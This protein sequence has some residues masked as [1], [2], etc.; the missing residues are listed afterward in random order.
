MRLTRHIIAG[1]PDITIALEPDFILVRGQHDIYAQ[2]RPRRQLYRR[3]QLIIFQHLLRHELC[4]QLL[5]QLLAVTLHIGHRQSTQLVAFSLVFILL[6]HE[7]DIRNILTAQLIA[8]SAHQLSHRINHYLNSSPVGLLYHIDSSLKLRQLTRN[9]LAHQLTQHAACPVAGV[10]R[11]ATDCLLQLR[12]QLRNPLLQKLRRLR[13]NAGKL[14]INN[15]LFDYAAPRPRIQ[16]QLSTGARLQLNIQQLIACKNTL[17]D[18][19]QQMHIIGLT[20]SNFLA[21]TLQE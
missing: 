11:R 7:Q 15:R 14:Q 4:R 18:F 6:L 20:C 12:L 21:V 5:L 2:I 3:L 1:T 10:Y 13:L 17:T 9:L 8:Y 19:L 16:H